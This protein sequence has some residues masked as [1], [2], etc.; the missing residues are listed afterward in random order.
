MPAR[1]MVN[2]NIHL[3]GEIHTWCY[4]PQFWPFVAECGNLPNVYNLIE[5]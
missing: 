2:V 1:E 4:T 3:I 5:S